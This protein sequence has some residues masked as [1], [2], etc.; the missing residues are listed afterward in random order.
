MSGAAGMTSPPPAASALAGTCPDGF[1]P[2]EGSNDFPIG[3]KMR[4]LL[5]HPKGSE[6][7][8]FML[9][10]PPAGLTCVLG[11]YTDH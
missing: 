1:T 2:K 5:S 4:K 10:P 7:S 3:G 8:A 6:P 9:K 11:R